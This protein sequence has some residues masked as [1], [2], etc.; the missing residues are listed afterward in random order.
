MRHCAA[1]EEGPTSTVNWGAE[2]AER[3]KRVFRARGSV[4]S[5]TSASEAS[6]CAKP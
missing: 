5:V 4:I 2:I 6:A 3:S 1:R